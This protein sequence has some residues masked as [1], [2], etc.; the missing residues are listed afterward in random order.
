MPHILLRIGRWVRSLT[1]RRK[2]PYHALRAAGLRSITSRHATTTTSTRHACWIHH[3]LE[4]EKSRR[5]ISAFQGR[6]EGGEG[7]RLGRGSVAPET[8]KAY[9]RYSLT[10]FTSA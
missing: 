2:R 8:S 6:T 1:R 9:D 5:Y 3:I 7:G 10:I 4:E